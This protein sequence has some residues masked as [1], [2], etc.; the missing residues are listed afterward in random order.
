MMPREHARR[1]SEP[2]PDEGGV[3]LGMPT[4]PDRLVAA[5][6]RKGVDLARA[7]RD[8]K[9]RARYLSALERGDYRELP[10]SV[11]TKG[12]LRNYALY[13]GLDPD[14]VLHQWRRESGDVG[15]PEPVTLSPRVVREPPRPFV[16][17]TRL[18]V[19][20]VMTLGVVLF[21][22]YLALQL[23]R[24]AKPPTLAV[25]SPAQAVVEVDENATSFRLE[26][27]ATPGVTVVVTVAGRD[28]P[29]LVTAL[30]DGS[31]SVEV[32]LRRGKNQFDIGATDPDTGKQAQ[33]PRTVVITVPYLVIQAPTL[34]VSQPVEGTTYENGAIP[35]EGSVTNASTVTVLATYLGPVG[36]GPAPKPTPTP[37]PTP[38]ASIDPSATPGLPPGTIS[39][40]VAEDGTFST[41]L[42]LT[43][44]RWSITVTAIS[45]QG[46]TASLT[47]T[48]TVAYKGVNLVIT[49]SGGNAWLKVWVDG[50]LA[51]GMSSGHVY[52]TG[53]TVTFSGT[54]SVTVWTGSSGNTFFTLNGVDLGALGKVGASET[55]QFLANGT[56]AP[57]AHP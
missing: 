9:I 41:P 52:R 50:T 38:A 19:A 25:T 15:D 13:L 28:H 7:E 33:T 26:G 4:L 5:R 48:V 12:F 17:S 10:G 49:M 40:A 31:W 53:Q 20:A 54:D 21:G 47:R 39:V 14:D 2:R 51:P 42:E 16:L 3:L 6:E 22:V 27:T 46:K 43:Q 45:P 1:T 57:T 29:Y 56:Y 34:V 32:D 11:Y 37:Q 44:G 23:L 24:F 35:L 36:G 18:V 30:A 8:T 55:W